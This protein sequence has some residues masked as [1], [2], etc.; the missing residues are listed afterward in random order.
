MRQAEEQQVV[1]CHNMSGHDGFSRLE[2]EQT[3]AAG[4]NIERYVLE[5]V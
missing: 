2:L 4:E 5:K 3:G 1:E